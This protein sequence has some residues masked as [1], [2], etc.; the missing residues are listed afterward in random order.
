M[1]WASNTPAPSASE[2]GRKCNWSLRPD[3]GPCKSVN[4]QLNKLVTS[5]RHITC[6]GSPF[7]TCWWVRFSISVMRSRQ[8]KPSAMTMANKGSWW[9][10]A[11]PINACTR[12]HEQPSREGNSAA[13][14]WNI[15]C[16]AAAPNVAQGETF[17]L[18]SC[19]TTIRRR[20]R[21]RDLH[22]Q[23]GSQIGG[24][25]GDHEQTI[26]ISSMTEAKGLEASR[27]LARSWIS[28]KVDWNKEKSG[29]R[30]H[31]PNVALPTKCLNIHSVQSLI[32]SRAPPK[33]RM[34]HIF[35]GATPYRP[36]SPSNSPPCKGPRVAATSLLA[37]FNGSPLSRQTFRKRACLSD[38]SPSRV[39]WH[40]LLN[41]RS[42]S[43]ES[44]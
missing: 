43:K 20:V 18:L 28:S 35:S 15:D 4:F 32:A 21:D 14:S 29:L 37:S 17:S 3:T 16:Y 22:V 12:C 19:T 10:K 9:K 24:H 31:I 6:R 23:L 11:K 1:S 25:H 36:T 33:P 41:R 5:N 39:S 38:G 27:R 40:P 26:I 44:R 34:P 30:K 7:T 42:W 8:L 13:N 2:K